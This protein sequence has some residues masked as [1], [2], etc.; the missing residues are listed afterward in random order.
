MTEATLQKPQSPAPLVALTDDE[1][2]F[3]DNIR[4]F[5]EESIRPHVREMDEKGVFHPDLIR[6]FFQLGIMGIEIPEQ[7]GGGAGTFFEAVLAVEEISRVD[8]SAGVIVDVQNTLVNNALLRWGSEDQKKR[9]LPRMATELVGAYALSEAGSGS[10]AFALQTRAE[11]KGG[12]Y[13][14]NGRK[15]WITNAKEAGL[16]VLL[17]TVDPAA[18]YKGITAFL[19]EKEFSGFSV[20]K[21]EDKLGIRASSTCELI[22]EDCRVPKA[23]VLGEVGKGYKIAIE[24]LNEGRI[25]IGAQMCGL[26]RGAWEHAARYAQERKQFGK[27]IAEFQGVQ[28][29]LAQ[30]ATELEAA[31]MMVY[32]AARMKDA[33]M[34]FVKEAA[35]T[36][37]FASQVAERVTSLAV[38]IYG[39]YGF[40]KDYPVEKYWRDSK[41][42]KIY[43]GTSNMQLAT[44]AKLVLG[45]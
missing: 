14:L 38:E 3:R 1:V 23:N 27:P 10:D 25:G 21:K 6:Q 11:L 5:A 13:V 44:I 35:M 9:Y 4:Q 15:L 34:N 28:F 24:T 42:G 16:F 19:V 33:G 26:A 22:L 45:R 20:G 17:A 29:Q 32:N 31:R 8:A 18:G 37:L 43:E 41:I 12:D 7:Y 40:T 30:A 39:G 36:K 2:L